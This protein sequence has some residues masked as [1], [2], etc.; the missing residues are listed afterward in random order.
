[1][2]NRPGR[3]EPC[4]CGSGKK[5]KKCCQASDQREASVERTIKEKERL[6][7]ESGKEMNAA[8]TPIPT[9]KKGA[10]DELRE[11]S[12]GDI[13]WDNLLAMKSPSQADAEAIIAELLALPEEEMVEWYE[14]MDCILEWEECDQEKLFFQMVTPLHERCHKQI[15]TAYWTAAELFFKKQER[16]PNAMKAV[17]TEYLKLKPEAYSLTSLFE[18]IELLLIA[19]MPDKSMALAERFLTV[20]FQTEDITA[21]GLTEFC[22]FLFEIRM[23]RSI[24]RLHTEGL[25]PNKEELASEIEEEL[26]PSIVVEAPTRITELTNRDYSFKMEDFDFCLT[27][28]VKLKDPFAPFGTLLRV[29]SQAYEVNGS[30]PEQSVFALCSAL[31]SAY[32]WKETPRK[33]GTK[34]RTIPNNLI[35]YLEPKGLEQRLVETASDFIG[36]HL[37]RALLILRGH[38][39]IC[40]CAEHNSLISSEDASQV[41]NEITKLRNK[42]IQ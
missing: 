4:H 34:K 10:E 8:N 20:A 30:D 13:L 11:P 5:Y 12:P 2:S 27:D 26:N 37:G 21:W 16:Y 6:E 15:N 32:C 14:V 18:V 39:L 22:V 42:L 38:E 7:A 25:H 23:G 28:D 31:R 36:V 9:Y 40:N 17:A 3:N 35:S 33:N 41:Y 19:G 29:A 1:M 24:R